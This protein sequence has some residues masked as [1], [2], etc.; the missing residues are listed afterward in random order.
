M[1]DSGHADLEHTNILAKEFGIVFNQ[2]CL[3]HVQDKQYENGALYISKSDSIFKHTKKI[4]KKEL[5]TI[6][7]TKPAKAHYKNN[8]GDVIMAISKIGKGT[9]KRAAIFRQNA[10]NASERANHA[11]PCWIMPH[12]RVS[13]ALPSHL[14]S[15]DLVII[16]EA[17]QSDFS[18]LPALLKRRFNS[19]VHNLSRVGQMR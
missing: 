2:N 12:W 16:D 6:S 13:E 18:A 1:N 19:E 15:F 7:L 11:V 17:S 10:R 4:Y 14:G 5:A 3:N 9:G 8:N